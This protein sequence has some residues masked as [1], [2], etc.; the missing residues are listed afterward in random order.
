MQKI[1][2][3]VRF[4][5]GI[6]SPL[7]CFKP[8]GFSDRILSPWGLFTVA[9]HSRHALKIKIC[10]IAGRDVSS[11]PWH[12]ALLGTAAWAVSTGDICIQ[13]LLRGDRH[14]N[15]NVWN[16]NKLDQLEGCLLLLRCY[17][18]R[19]VWLLA[20]ALVREAALPSGHQHTRNEI[21]R[22]IAW[23]VR[24][25]PNAN[26]CDDAVAWNLSVN[27]RVCDHRGQLLSILELL[28]TGSLPKQIPETFFR[29]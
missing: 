4:H 21:H 17:G 13:R 3:F 24:Q 12:L 10:C 20:V 26:H 15:A 11:V 28:F 14:R 18:S 25:S 2:R 22:K 27:A 7:C 19:V 8:H 23:R 1:R 9:K 29:L 5:L 16:P 6:L